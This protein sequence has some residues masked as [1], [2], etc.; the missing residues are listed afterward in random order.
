MCTSTQKID[1]VSIDSKKYEGVS[2]NSFKKK[3]SQKK[4]SKSCAKNR[5]FIMHIHYLQ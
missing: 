5:F 1:G 3:Q 2:F 4:K